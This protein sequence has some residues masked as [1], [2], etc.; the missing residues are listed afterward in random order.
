LVGVVVAQL[1]G[2]ACLAELPAVFFSE[3]LKLVVPGGDIVDQ[4]KVSWDGAC[5]PRGLALSSGEEDFRPPVVVA[6]LRRRCC[7]QARWGMSPAV[8]QG[9]RRHNLS[10]R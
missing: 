6:W 5:G 2:G 7:G 8:G 10:G 3:E 4:L 9:G 1:S